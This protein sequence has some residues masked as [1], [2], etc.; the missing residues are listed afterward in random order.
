LRVSARKQNGA[1]KNGAAARKCSGLLQFI[2]GGQAQHLASKVG[3]RKQ[4]VCVIIKRSGSTG[5]AVVA[6]NDTAA[7][8]ASTARVIGIA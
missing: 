2:H 5:V 6:I 1:E 8:D 3:T 7:A 4:S